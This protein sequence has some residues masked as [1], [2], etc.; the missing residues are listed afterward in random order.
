MN[1]ATVLGFAQAA[2]KLASGDAACERAIRRGQAKLIVVAE[3]A[4]DALAR[5]FLR[6]AEEYAV[7]CLRW[8]DKASLGAW[9]GERPRAVVVVCDSRFARMLQSAVA[10]SES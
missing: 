4:G 5:R 1:P 9:I 7:P 2:G 8:G 6:L 3:D 10:E